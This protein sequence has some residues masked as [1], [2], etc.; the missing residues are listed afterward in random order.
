M[1]VS[2]SVASASN[3]LYACQNVRWTISRA[4]HSHPFFTLSLSLSVFH[5]SKSY[6]Q[7]KT[8]LVERIFVTQNIWCKV[9][10]KCYTLV[11]PLSRINLLLCRSTSMSLWNKNVYAYIVCMNVCMF[12]CGGVESVDYVICATD[13]ICALEHF[14]C[15]VANTAAMKSHT[16]AGR[17]VLLVFI[18]TL[19]SQ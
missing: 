8:I 6:S 7:K 16:N 3:T 19:Q 4:F 17:C 1:I 14:A 11:M 18:Y 9:V 10:S 13:I 12:V 15:G 5:S 2:G